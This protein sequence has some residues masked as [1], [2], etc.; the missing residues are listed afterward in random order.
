VVG[1][2]TVDPFHGEEFPL[3]ASDIKYCSSGCPKNQLVDSHSLGMNFI[4]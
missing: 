3:F 2:G 1:G 4:I